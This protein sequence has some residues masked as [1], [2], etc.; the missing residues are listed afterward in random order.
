VCKFNQ[1]LVAFVEFGINCVFVA[2]QLAPDL[3]LNSRMIASATGIE[4][5]ASPDYLFQAA[6]KVYDLERVF[7]FREGFRGADDMLP[8]RVQKEPLLEAEAATG[9]TFLNLRGMIQ[10]YYQAR[11]W[12]QEG[13][14]PPEKLRAYGLEQA[15]RD[16]EA[17]M[18]E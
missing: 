18:N 15:A 16:I 14:P 5:C 7:V 17:I 3:G 10:E 8:E 1:D 13:F 12:S 11:G 9:Q 2:A 6:E 4:A